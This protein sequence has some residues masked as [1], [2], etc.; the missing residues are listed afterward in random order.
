MNYFKSIITIKNTNQD[1]YKDK[2]INK[3]PYIDPRLI[4]RIVNIEQEETNKRQK[5]T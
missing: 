1:V 2:K 4:N 3:G 5:L